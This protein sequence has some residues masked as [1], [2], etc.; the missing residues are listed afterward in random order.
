MNVSDPFWKKIAH[1]T[2]F[3]SKNGVY[4]I[5]VYRFYPSP[6]ISIEKERNTKNENMKTLTQTIAKSIFAFW[7]LTF[8]SCSHTA[9]IKKLKSDLAQTETELT[10][11]KNEQLEKQQPTQKLVHL[12]YLKL[13]KDATEQ[14][15]QAVIAEMKKLE[16]IEQV[17]N[18]EVGTFYDLK[19]KRAMSEFD[20]FMQMRFDN[21]QE[22][23]KYQAHPIH[24]QLKENVKAYLGG[25]PVTYDYW[26]K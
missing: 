25:S 11:I 22:Y 1:F 12:V 18:L 3:L 17:H 13:K 26:V 20:L 16:D 7:I 24:L 2:Y 19:D 21:E 14:D 5:R 8:L 6:I 15:K 23:Q 10:Q 4:G 9:E